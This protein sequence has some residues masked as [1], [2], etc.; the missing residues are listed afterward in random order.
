[1]KTQPA[2]GSF[3]VYCGS[4]SLTVIQTVQQ[5]SYLHQTVAG[6]FKI[7]DFIDKGGMG[8][9][10]LGKN[11]AIGQ[12]VAIKFLHKKFAADEHLVMR[13]LNEARS[14]CKV[15]HPNAVTLLEYGQHTDGSLYIITE[16]I[17][18]KSLSKTL[19]DRG[20][21]DLQKVIS[22]GKQICEVL[23]AAHE[24]GVIHRDLKPDNIMLTPGPKDRYQVKV[25]D[26]GIAKITDEDSGPMTETGAIFGTPEF[27][28]PE[29]ARGD[30]AEPRSDLYALGLILFYMVTGKLPFKGKNKFAVLHKHIN[31]DAPKPSAMAPY[32]QISPALEALILK[33]LEK[34]PE[35]RYSSADELYD[36]LEDL[37]SHE[38]IRSTTHMS[39]DAIHQNA[40][41][42]IPELTTDEKFVS[43]D[44]LA[45][46][47][48]DSWPQQPF[49]LADTL[50]P[51][52]TPNVRFDSIDLSNEHG[53][54]SDDDD[55][56]WYPPPSRGKRIMLGMIAGVLIAGGIFAF[57]KFKK[58]PQITPTP[59][60]VQKTV[61]PD[62]NVQK[63][64]VT[65]QVLALLTTAQDALDEGE[66]Q[67]ARQQLEASRLW[68]N[69]EDL[70]K[71]GML[72]R[73]ELEKR[74]TSLTT[75]D[76]SAQKLIDAGQCKAVLTV[77]N[78]IQGQ[79]QG[80][81]AQWR[82]RAMACLR[83][84]K[85]GRGS[86]NKVVPK[87]P[88]IEK[89]VPGT[90]VP[91]TKNPDKK[92]SPEETQVPKKTSETPSDK[93]APKADVKPVDKVD[94]KDGKVPEKTKPVPDGMALPPKTL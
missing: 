41:T 21:F 89:I 47:E 72:L 4:K 17:E 33:C 53:A 8:E 92:A 1:M 69:D 56:D 78:N 79:S 36:T 77:A 28:S 29:Q 16:F 46:S 85:R 57:W 54:P 3:C 13:F 25:L 44:Q 2:S 22:V 9:V 60:V 32:L 87:L 11:E 74:L 34:D 59:K 91:G 55:L 65:G 58:A 14:Y 82:Q 71:K 12:K 70:P 37:R 45:P 80:L 86:K 26:F 19:K 51:H 76:D 31:D 23:T 66:L 68:L 52:E 81:S 38:G 67:A 90:I 6:K 94:A 42:P 43:T 75:S 20:P 73:L 48:E 39:L 83:K 15:N 49:E 64:L 27:M 84:N 40:P 61:E 35:D 88:G 93:A 62:L 30:G 5:E 18:G 24:Q 63:I 50:S 10:Y 7:V